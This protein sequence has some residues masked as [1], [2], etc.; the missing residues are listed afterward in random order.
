MPLPYCPSK[1]VIVR[2]CETK[3]QGHVVRE[4]LRER[5]QQL[6]EE[7]EEHWLG[8]WKKIILNSLFYLIL[9]LSL[10]LA[11]F[12]ST[13]LYVFLLCYLLLH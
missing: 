8:E 9:S 7:K 3:E 11:D 2:M 12:F 1:S 13:S 10:S 6:W 5:E 4:L